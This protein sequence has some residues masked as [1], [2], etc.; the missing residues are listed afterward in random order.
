MQSTPRSRLKV[1][2]VGGTGLVGR[3]IVEALVAAGSERVTATHHTRPNFVA[4]G[5]DWVRCD[6][7]APGSVRP[8]LQGIDVAV[9]C[10]GRVSTSSVLRADPVASVLDTLRVV[11][12]VLEV[13]AE[14]RVPRVILVS[15]CTGYP[16]LPGA[17]VEGDM[18]TGDPPAGWFGVGWMHRYLEAQVRWYAEHLGRFGSAISLRPSLIY[19]PYDDF[20]SE[21]GHFV[22]AMI[23]RVVD[24]ERPIEV[25]GDGTQSRNLLHAADLAEAILAVLQGEA[26]YEAFNVT[27]RDDVTVNELLRHLLDVDG[28]ND[29]VVKHDLDRVPGAAA[30]SVSGQAFAAAKAWSSRIGFKQGVSG[31]LDWYRRSLSGSR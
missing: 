23:R 12:N 25:W 6:L 27:S 8:A 4:K 14:L 28:F 19:G 1:G 9:L 5:V 24:R 22:P 15:S 11:T 20:A 29:A 30:L 31:T 7:R 26:R 16:E 3:H 13:A 18:F 21:T 10:A 2:V 17:A